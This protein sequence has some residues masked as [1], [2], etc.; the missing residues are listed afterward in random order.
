MI[1]RRLKLIKMVEE[2]FDNSIKNCALSL[3]MSISQV[4]KVLRGTANIGLK[5][6]ECIMRYCIKMEID[7]NL[8]V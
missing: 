1:Q 8:Y 6:M 5:F 3:K 2:C 7:H 4:G